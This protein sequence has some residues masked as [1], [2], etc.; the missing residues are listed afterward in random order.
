MRD[1]LTKKSRYIPKRLWAKIEKFEGAK[2]P[3]E[4]ILR[5]LNKRQI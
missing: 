5:I 4:E 3:V 1:R 2:V